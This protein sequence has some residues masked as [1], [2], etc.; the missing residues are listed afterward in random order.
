MA[1]AATKP[2]YL[3]NGDRV[4]FY[5]DSITEQRFYTTDVELYVRT[6]FPNLH[7]R[8]VN[9]GVGGDTVGGGWAGPIN[10][11]LKRDVF[12]F[13]PN[14]VTIMLGMN[15][16]GYQ[17]FNPLLFHNYRVG[18]EHIIQSLKSHLPG[19]RIVLIAPS[20]FDDV[21]FP[22]QFP[23]GYNTVLIRYGRLVKTLAAKYHLAYVNF[24]KPLVNVLQ[25]A[26][27]VN[28]QLAQQIIPQ[29]VHPA[30]NGQLVMAEALLKA[31]NAPAIVTA[32]NI[33]ADTRSIVQSD[34]TRV[35]AISKS[36]GALSWTQKDQ[37]L[38]MPI[39]DLH[40]NWPQFPPILTPVGA[41][42]AAFA[43][44]LWMPPKPNWNYINP[45]TALVV[46]LC[47]LYHNVDSETLRVTGLVAPR[48]TLKI[49]DHRVA[50][51]SKQ[52][53]AT[54]INLARYDTPMM[55]QAYRVLRRIWRE[56]QTR[57][58]IWRFIQL[59]LGKYQAGEPWVTEAIG[60]PFVELPQGKSKRAAT[61]RRILVVSLYENLFKTATARMYALAVPVSHTFK[62][63]PGGG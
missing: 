37:S 3:K 48:Y 45:V 10:L 60:G 39:M 36:K 28:P 31:W 19:V 23:G 30:A 8:F 9:S 55:A 61:A 57:F 40:E 33:D 59:P 6:R 49:D 52:Q 42:Y 24:N 14:V 26:K 2:F 56:T 13:K 43:R 4:V 35:S 44:S 58:Y 63:V 11:R 32:V 46:K 20:P 21:T 27:K 5:G 51:F 1:A 22:P 54:G 38:P 12:A 18:Y 62:L 7:V 29:R 34:N 25:K 53:L 17:A 16:G 15:D 41:P 47:R 50:V